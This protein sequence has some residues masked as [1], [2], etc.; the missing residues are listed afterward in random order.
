M[1][2]INNNQKQSTTLNHNPQK[3]PTIGNSIQH[4][5]KNQ[6]QSTTVKNNK[7]QPRTM[8]SSQQHSATLNDT[9]QQSTSKDNN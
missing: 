9:K 8:N 1:D 6:Q 2:T 5:T 3:P 7:Q 4:S